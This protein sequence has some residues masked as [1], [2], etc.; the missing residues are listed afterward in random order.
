M[1]KYVFISFTGTEDSP[2]AEQVYLAVSKDGLHFKDLNNKQP[3]LRSDIGEKGVRDMYLVKKHDHTGYYLIA[4]DLSIYHRGGWSNQPTLN[5]SKSLLVWET[6]DLINWSKANLVKIVPDNVGMVWA[7]E[8]VWDKQKEAY[9][10]FW[11]SKFLDG[12]DHVVIGSAYTKDF[13]QFTKPEVFIKRGDK[14]DIIDTTIAYDGKEYVR[15]SR[16]DQIT[17]EKSKDLTGT[18]DKVTTLQDLDLGIHGDVVE[19]P[20]FCYL[21]NQHKWCMYVDQF[22]NGKGY[23][24][25]LTTDIASSDPADWQVAEDYDFGDLKKRH[26]TI[27]PISDE[28]YERL[29]EHQSTTPE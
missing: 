5:G 15:A 19:G 21:E 8:A 7:P 25:I 24:P 11:A 27:Q 13:K 9:F 2:D 17:I 28:E 20:E 1:T 3:I 18:W 12:K 4:T 26:G 16:D 29:I 23:L 14:Q 22:D 10:V 6:P